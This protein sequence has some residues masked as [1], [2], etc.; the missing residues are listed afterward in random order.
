LK[1]AEKQDK[2]AFIHFA[3]QIETLPEGGTNFPN[4]THIERIREKQ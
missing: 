3:N 2:S 1:T 4:A